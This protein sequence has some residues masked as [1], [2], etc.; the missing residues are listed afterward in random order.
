MLY[1][2]SASLSILL[3]LPSILGFWRHGL[4]VLTFSSLSF[5][6]ALSLDLYISQMCHCSD[7]HRWFTYREQG[8]ERTSC[9]HGLIQEEKACRYHKYKNLMTKVHHLDP[10]L[11]IS[12]HSPN[13]KYRLHLFSKA[14]NTRYY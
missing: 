1:L 13:F 10:I 2:N 12:I 14:E 4:I 3:G 5:I 8:H 6:N 9:L 7:I 11:N